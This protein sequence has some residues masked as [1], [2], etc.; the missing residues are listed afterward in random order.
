MGREKDPAYLVLRSI[1]ADAKQDPIRRDA[2]LKESIP[3]FGAVSKMSDFHLG[4][5][6]TAAGR[7]DDKVQVQAA[8]EEQKKR[9]TVKAVDAFDGF[10]PD[11]GES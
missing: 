11:R 5:Y 4:W 3:L 2:W 8:Q 9:R 10:L 6:V 7:L 1:L